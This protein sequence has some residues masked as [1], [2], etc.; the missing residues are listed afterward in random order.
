MAS[1]PVIW[2]EVY[3]DDMERARAF[4]QSVLGVT[5]E[6]MPSPGGMDGFEMLAFPSSMQ[7]N[8]ASGALCRMEGMSPGVGGSL[9]Y[10]RCDDCAVEAG[11][12]EAAGGKLH[13]AKTSIG[14]HGAIALALDTEGNMFGLHSMG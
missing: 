7:G 5:L 8:G 9:V 2:F 3:V 10:F 14:E 12:V 1:N 6:P 4:Y 11:R 13:Q